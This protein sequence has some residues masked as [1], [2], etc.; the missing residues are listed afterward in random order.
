MRMTTTILCAL[1]GIASLAFA[2]FSIVSIGQVM[3]TTGLSINGVK[4]MSEGRA[5]YGGMLGAMGGLVLYALVREPW[6]KPILLSVGVIYAAM[7]VSRLVSS[8]LDGFDPGLMQAVAT[9][10]VIAAILLASAALAD[11]PPRLRPDARIAGITR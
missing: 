2:V 8:L 6:R 3:P 4:G 7:V 1:V 11:A 5:I 9:E 10:T